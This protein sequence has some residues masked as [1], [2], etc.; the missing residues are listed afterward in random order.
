MTKNF[1]Q[2]RRDDERH[3]SRRPSGRYEGE[4]SPKPARPRPN[5]A[6]VDRAW[7][8][9]ARQQHP[10]YHP[11]SAS[12]SQHTHPRQQGK[13]YQA[14]RR[15]YAPNETSSAPTSRT[16]RQRPFQR[17]ENRRFDDRPPRQYEGPRPFDSDRRAHDERQYHQRPRFPRDGEEREQ[18]STY[19]GQRQNTRSRPY[20]AR[21]YDARDD[22]RSERPRAPGRP[23]RYER[24]GERDTRY[25]REEN[26]PETSNTRY[27]RNPRFQSRPDRPATYGAKR[28][29]AEL[30]EGDYE[31]FDAGDDT[32]H[33]D[34]AEERVARP[35]DGRGLSAEDEPRTPKA[36]KATRV[37]GKPA[38]R[39]GQASRAAKSPAKKH[40]G[41]S[42]ANVTRPSQRG[43]KWPRPE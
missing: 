21:Q 24:S 42:H 38:A 18:R 5:R 8:N 3:Y 7:E 27:Q 13:P 36:H 1:K 12:N 43:Y 34:E 33:N 17:P 40:G 9:G 31:H 25:R 10:D 39:A 30:F 41:K 4:Q 23:Q 11:R 29:D 32:S 28:A 16:Y 14:N 15:P 20:P 2:P 35:P 26:R 37:P 19:G 22:A 6:S